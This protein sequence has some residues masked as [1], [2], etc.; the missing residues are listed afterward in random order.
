VLY[1]DEPDRI[2]LKLKSC[3]FKNDLLL[4]HKTMQFVELFCPH[5]WHLLNLDFFTSFFDKFVDDIE[6]ILFSYVK[7]GGLTIDIL[8]IK[9]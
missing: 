9:T 2:L 3:T 4:T 1:L 8:I 7:K 5:D 6:P